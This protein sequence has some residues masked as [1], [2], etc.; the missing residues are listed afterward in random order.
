MSPLLFVEGADLLQSLV[1][2]A[3]RDGLLSAPIPMR[4]D[5]QIIPYADDTIVV[6]PANK[7]D[8]KVFKDILNLYAAF[9]GLRI[10][11]HKL[12]MIPINM[13]Q[14]EIVELAAF[15]ECNLGSIPFTYLGLPMGTIRL[16]IRDMSPLTDR[17]E[18]RPS[19]QLL[20]YPMGIDWY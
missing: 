10:N 1:N 8:L 16:T 19:V 9:T 5:Y 7:N 14:E 6:L 18:R 4:K 13:S 20:F 2:K 11:F 3:F 17:V 15:F 12:S